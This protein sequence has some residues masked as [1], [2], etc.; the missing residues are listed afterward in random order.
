MGKPDETATLDSLC[1]RLLND[2]AGVHQPIGAKIVLLD[3][4]LLF[5][6][7]YLILG[8]T[9]FAFFINLKIPG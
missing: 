4:T 3:V 8:W 6:C 7:P 1:L 9:I 2:L 5:I